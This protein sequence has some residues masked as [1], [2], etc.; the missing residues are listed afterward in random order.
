MPVSPRFR[1]PPSSPIDAGQGVLQTESKEPICRKRLL[2]LFIEALRVRHY[3]PRTEQAYISWV[4]R[5]VRFND[6]RHPAEL[7]RIEVERYLAHLATTGGVSASTQSQALAALL[8]FYDA[9]L[10]TPLESIEG[11]ARA[12]RSTHIPVVLTSGEV[13]RLLER[14]TG[15]PALMAALLYGSGLRVLECVSL[16]VKDLDL[17][18]AEIRIRDGKGAKDRLVPIAHG[19]IEPLR[20]HLMAR[21]HQY[22]ADLRSGAGWVEL[23]EALERKYPNAGNEW[24][25][26]WV[27]AATRHYVHPGSG[28]LRRHHYHETALQRAVREAAWRAQ[29]NKHV[30]CHAL[31][32]SFATHLLEAGYDIRTIQELLGHRSV[33]TTMIYTHVLNRGGLGV[34]SPFDQLPAAIPQATYTRASQVQIQPKASPTPWPPR[35]DRTGDTDYSW[36]GGAPDTEPAQ[37]FRFRTSISETPPSNPGDPPWRRR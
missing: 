33:A 31:R 19:L 24:I 2:Q 7:G 15:A 23:P 9:V 4:R 3:S 30:H 37:G 34:R 14:M 25:W 26:Q 18:R 12:K 13:Q 27:F 20:V 29:I 11:L 36:F 32:H 16:R 5:F 6:N 10:A 17:S 8:F 28:Q 22:D 1:A 35:Q 21:R